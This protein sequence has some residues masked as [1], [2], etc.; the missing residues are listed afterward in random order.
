M[1]TIKATCPTCG[2]VDLT[3][4]EMTVTVAVEAGWSTYSFTCATCEQEISK[5]AD[6]EIVRLL[7][8][9]GVRVR[10][11]NVPGEFLQSQVLNRT[12][13]PLTEDDLLDFALWLGRDVD[14]I[15]AAN[16]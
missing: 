2:D 10:H 8:G 15:S 3:P 12:R 5:P 9:A 13:P 7:T 1:T 16:P 4:T 11:V 6:D 14:V